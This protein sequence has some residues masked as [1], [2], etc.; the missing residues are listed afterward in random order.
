[1]LHKLFSK[2]LS[3]DCAVISV[4]AGGVTQS[5]LCFLGKSGGTSIELLTRTIICSHPRGSRMGAVVRYRA[6]L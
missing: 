1:M 3:L 4:V 5:L 2:E 6:G